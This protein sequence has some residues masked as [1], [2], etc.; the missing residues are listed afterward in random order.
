MLLH[1][2]I[3]IQLHR[4]IISSQHADVHISPGQAEGSLDQLFVGYE[5]RISRSCR[6]GGKLELSALPHAYDPGLSYH[7]LSRIVIPGPIRELAYTV[8]GIG[9]LHILHLG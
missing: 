6:A 5:N 9:A 2:G 1:Q 7:H 3:G 4:D 8:G